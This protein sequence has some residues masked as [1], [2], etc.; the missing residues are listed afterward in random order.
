MRE[1]QPDAVCSNR[2]C[3]KPAEATL[4]DEPYCVDCLDELVDRLAAVS[5]RPELRDLL[6][7][8]WT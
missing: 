1:L 8:L 7:E 2:R 4:D 5:Q 6:P 3:L